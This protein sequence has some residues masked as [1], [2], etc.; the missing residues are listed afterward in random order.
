[1][2]KFYA[3][4]PPAL[5]LFFKANFLFFFLLSIRLMKLKTMTLKIIISAP[6]LQKSTQKL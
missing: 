6:D 4:S 1:M 3:L 2:V 5:L